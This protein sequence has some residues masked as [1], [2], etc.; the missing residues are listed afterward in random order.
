MNLIWKATVLLAGASVVAH[1]LRRSAAATRHALWTAALL[2]I[3]LLPLLAAVLPAGSAGPADDFLLRLESV[4][5]AAASPPAQALPLWIFGA[6]TLAVRWLRSWWKVRRLRRG[7]R[8]TGIWEGVPVLICAE[9]VSPLV[10]GCFRPAILLPP[11]SLAWSDALRT[12]VLLH[13]LGHVQR[14]DCLWSGLG[15]LICAAWWFHPLAWWALRRMRHEA[16]RACDDRVLRSGVVPADYAS[17]LLRVARTVWSA[18][19]AAVPMIGTAPFERRV[20]GI[21]DPTLNRGSGRVVLVALTSLAV[22]VPLACH[23]GPY[24]VSANPDIRP[25][26]LLSKVDANYTPQAKDAKIQGTVKLS[27]VVDRKG[28]ARDI[29]VTQGLDPG[30]DHNAVAAIQ[31]WSFEPARKKDRPVDVQAAVEVHYRLN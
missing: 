16:E 7:S 13:E 28:K 8:R 11:S 21:L 12:S 23:R 26:R 10:T 27:L 6:V 24:R 22:L 19:A 2:S 9:E 17:Y 5:S 14:R 1:F 20:R 30:L 4:A 3:A 18:P 31:Q 29:R 25:P 15:A